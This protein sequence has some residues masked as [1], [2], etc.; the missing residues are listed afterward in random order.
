M[1]NNNES[2]VDDEEYMHFKNLGEFDKYIEKI[3]KT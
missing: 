2:I 1:E 3:R